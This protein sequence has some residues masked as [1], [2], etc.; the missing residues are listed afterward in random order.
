M[1]SVPPQPPHVEAILPDTNETP[2]GTPPPNTQYAV[3]EP[4]HHVDSGP[5]NPSNDTPT[6]AIVSSMPATLL[7]ANL[8]ITNGRIET[9]QPPEGIPSCSLQD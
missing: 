7:F 1:V 2:T 4:G 5:D 9:P 6:R 8:F 3:Q